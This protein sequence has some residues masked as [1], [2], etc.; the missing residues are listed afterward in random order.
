M[1]KN[2]LITGGCGFIGKNLILNLLTYP[3]IQHIVSLDNFISSNEDDF[4]SFKKTYDQNNIIKYYNIDITKFNFDDLTKLYNIEINEIYHLASIASPPLYKMNPVET[5]DV[6]YIGT[7]NVLEYAKNK[8]IKVLFA[9]TSEIYGD[10]KINPQSENYY[11]NVNCFGARSCYDES[12]RISEALCYT[13]INNYNMDVKIARIFNTYGEFMKLDD[14]R[15]ITEAIK[16]M[17]YD[18]PLSIHGTGFQTRSCCYVK[19]TVNM[20][21]KLMESSHR[22]PVNIGNN[23][24]L[25]VIDTITIIEKVYKNTIN[26]FTSLKYKYIP[27]TQDDPLQRQPCLK[28]NK[29]LLGETCY[30]SFEN[31]IAN[32]IKYFVDLYN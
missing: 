28:L 31:G 1:G 10:A 19:D 22:I 2:I 4:I 8:K 11:G 18:K 13:Y 27:L 15:I 32:T 17:M 29:E 21:I 14:G 9:S 23:I 16:S 5:L 30:T 20:L 6:G 3:N 7:R 25:S 12:K 26:Q 24:E